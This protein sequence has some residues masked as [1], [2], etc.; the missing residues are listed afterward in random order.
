VR[1]AEK[2]I[3]WSKVQDENAIFSI[4]L[5]LE[6]SSNVTVDREGH[7]LKQ[8]VRMNLT[9]AGIQIDWSDKHSQNV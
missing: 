6:L 1:E 3:D 2:R 9:D 7:V 5:S 4:R 8:S